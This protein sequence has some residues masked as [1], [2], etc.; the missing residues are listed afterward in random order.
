MKRED[1]VLLM[2]IIE[3]YKG[4]KVI[5]DNSRSVH[6]YDFLMRIINKE[7]DER[8]NILGF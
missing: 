7:I 4:M 3:L 5:G 2:D 8:L 1:F 6:E